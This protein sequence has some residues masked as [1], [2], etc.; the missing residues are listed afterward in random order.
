[1]PALLVALPWGLLVGLPALA[2]LACFARPALAAVV[3]AAAV[4]GIA[5]ALV[6]L[7][8]GGSLGA[9]VAFGSFGRGAL[10]LALAG[11]TVAMALPAGPDDAPPGVLWLTTLAAVGLVLLSRT[12]LL[13]TATLLLVAL[14]VPAYGPAGPGSAWRRTLAAGAVVLFFGFVAER[15][16]VP[17][18]TDLSLAG[19]LVGGFLLVLG[20]TP[21]GLAQVRWLRGAGH[22]VAVVAG[23]CL[24]PAL[25]VVASDWSGALGSLHLLRP[26]RP[27]TTIAVFAALTLVGVALHALTAR[28][29]R[30]LAADGIVADLALAV[31][32]VGVGSLDGA[33][34]ALVALVVVRPLMLLLDR[35]ALPAG[36]GRLATLAALAG[37][38][39]MPPAV[40]FAARLLVLGA[41]LGAGDAVV[42]LLV[43]GLV[44]EVVATG[45]VVL[46][47]VAARDAVVAR[48]GQILVAGVLPVLGLVAGL[49]PGGV[50]ERVWGG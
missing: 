17:Q 41:A 28:G 4:A 30:D 25:V 37:A 18:V 50:L 32:A 38:A 11:I 45:R 40:S 10:W 21:F 24:G 12:P 39:G 16:A 42:A 48:P 20:M 27:A 29:W 23:C 6:M 46:R 31:L 22:R 35:A 15:L 36:L 26:N 2:T 14:V 7:P 43:V 3:T 47:R 19:A 13:V 8:A 34:L 9:T 44:V 33:A 5:V 49:F 1:M